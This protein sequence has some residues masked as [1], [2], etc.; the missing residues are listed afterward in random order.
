MREAKLREYLNTLET[1]QLKEEIVEVFKVF[2]DVKNYYNLKI[3]GKLEESLLRA[4]K[5]RLVEEFSNYPNNKIRYYKISEIL[6]EFQ[7]ISTR[8]YDKVDL[9][10]YYID[11]AMGYIQLN[12]IRD[13][14]LIISLEGVF[15]KA[16]NIIFKN[17]LQEQFKEA[18]ELI[19]NKN[20]INSEDLK[21]IL[22]DTKNNF[23]V[24]LK[25]V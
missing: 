8:A 7:N 1:N 13:E 18:I 20:V 25:K 4:C 15:E 24:K 11:L 9:M 6:M 17:N 16:L 22:Q 2:D 19:I 23:Q 3:S 12:G 10:L 21:C 5:E 14:K